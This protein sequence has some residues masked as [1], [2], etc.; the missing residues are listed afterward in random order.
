MVFFSFLVHSFFTAYC[1]SF[2]TSSVIIWSFSVPDEIN[3]CV[4]KKNVCRIQKISLGWNLL[5]QF[6]FIP[7]TKLVDKTKKF[8]TEPTF[9]CDTVNLWLGSFRIMPSMRCT[10]SSVK[11]D[12]KFGSCL[13]IFA[14]NDTTLASRKGMSPTTIQ[15]KETPNEYTSAACKTTSLTFSVKVLYK[16]STALKATPKRNEFRFLTAKIMKGDTRKEK[17]H[18]S[19]VVAGFSP[20]QCFGWS[21][22]WSSCSAG[23]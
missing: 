15:Y 13:W 9:I 4:T 3:D 14:Y 12:G 5:S 19:T 2:L 8:S 20:R 11:C 21:E 22:R 18:F 7:T 10:K 1:A 6:Q 17:T 16:E 23:Q